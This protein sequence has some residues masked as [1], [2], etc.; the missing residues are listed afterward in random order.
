MFSWFTPFPDWL[1]MIDE[2]YPPLFGIPTIVK[3]PDISIASGARPKLTP[4]GFHFKSVMF[5]RHKCKS[6]AERCCGG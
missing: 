3:G 1:A 4:S 5:A 6:I 2:A